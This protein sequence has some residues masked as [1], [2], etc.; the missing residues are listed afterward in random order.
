MNKVF[1]N[2][3]MEE[4]GSFIK[5]VESD[6]L[7]Q[8]ADIINETSINKGKVIVAGN[9]GSASIASHISI[10][11]SKAVGV[12]SINFNEAGLITCLANDYS[13]ETWLVEA[14]RMYSDR[15]D[16]L[17]LISSS[18]K[19][20]NI[21]NAAEFAKSNGLPLITF[22]GFSQDNPLRSLGDINFYVDSSEYNYVEI[23]HSVWLVA[24][25]DYLRLYKK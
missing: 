1:F 15:H 4:L 14:L 23:A 13:Y 7:M 9:G 10:D 8:A 24:L 25:V 22:S 11:L 19:S 21:V 3:Y 2:S 17:I 6:A 18:G 5:D 12:R 20:P 16:S